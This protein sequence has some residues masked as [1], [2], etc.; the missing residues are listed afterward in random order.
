[1]L[2]GNNRKFPPEK[3]AASAGKLLAFVTGNYRDILL[4][5]CAM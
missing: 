3:Y 1:M 2:A 4:G 5:S